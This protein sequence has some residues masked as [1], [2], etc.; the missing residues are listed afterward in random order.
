MALPP[1]FA[2]S[3]LYD[4]LLQ[5]A[6][7]QFFGRATFETEPI[8]SLSSDGR[9]AIEPTNDPSVLT[10]RWFGSRLHPAR[11]RAPPVHAARSPPRARDRIGPGAAL[12]GDLRSEADAGADGAVPR[13]D[14][15]PLRQRVPRFAG[16]GRDGRIRAPT[17]SRPPS[18]CCA[19]RRSRATRTMRSRPASCCSK[20]TKIAS[21]RC[22]RRATACRTATRRR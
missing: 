6:L 13:R 8:P 7:R 21:T 18:R 15:G 2:A 14:R 1:V 16:A 20:A 10:I 22:R 3:A 12:P 5:A 4:S 17:C 19:S 9:L 11:A